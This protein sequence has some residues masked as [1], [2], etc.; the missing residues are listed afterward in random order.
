MRLS[1]G[2]LPT[3]ASTVALACLIAGPAT[4][5]ETDSSAAF[6]LEEIVVTAQKTVET[7]SKTPIALSVFSDEQ[8]KDSGVHN[9]D[10]L[11]SIAP[12]VQ[13]ANGGHGALITIRGVTTTDN[14]S[15]GEQAV[16][17]NIDGMAIGRPQI[18][19]LAFFDLE[20]VEVL[21]GP[22]GTLYGKSSTGGAINVITAKPKSDFDAAASVE[23]GNYNTRRAEGMVNVPVTDTFAIRLAANSNVRDGFLNP[24]LHYG[25]PQSVFT[26]PALN[27]EDNQSGRLSALWNFSDTGSLLLQGTAGHIGGTGNTSGR[28]LFYRYDQSGSAAREVYANPMASGV[29][30]KYYKYNAEL[31]MDVGAMRLTYVGGY[32][33]FKGNDNPTPSTGLPTGDNPT[34]SWSQYIADNT[35]DSHEVR[36]SNAQPQRL[37]YVL[38]ANYWKEV[39]DEVDM[40][41]QTYANISNTTVPGSNPPCTVPAPNTV[42]GCSAPSPNIV[43]VNQHKAQGYFGQLNFHATDALKLTAGLRY[44]SDSMFRNASIA[45]GP[46]PAAYWT[47]ANGQP[48]YPGV[49]C[50]P[51]VNGLTGPVKMND[52]G[53]QAADK[54]T[55]RIGADYQ[56]GDN[57]MIYGYVA[58]GYKAGSFNDICPTVSPP[59]PCSYG[60]EDMIAYEVGYKGR[61]RPNLEINSSVY[62]YDYS[63][64]Q[65]TQPTFL[66]PNLSGGAPTVII[67]TTLV[68][69][70][71]YGWEG[72]MHWNITGND[73]F[74]ISMT[75]ANG[76]YDDGPGHAEAGLGYLVRKDWSNK[77]LD[78]LPKWSSIVSYEHRW[79][80]SGGG[81][82]SARLSSKISDS[83]YQSELGGVY[84]GP[85]FG[86]PPGSPPPFNFT[87]FAV[88]PTQYEQASFT[89]TD[90]NLGYTSESGKYSVDAYVR[91]IEDKMQLQS[92]PQNVY[93]PGTGNPDQV[94]AAVNAPL[95]MGIRMSVKY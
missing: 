86:G 80:M 85:P 42:A 27:D 3:A 37:E 62:Y 4:G 16:S 25:R 33:S 39:T 36:I 68:P 79:D 2:L 28:A 17:F 43:G 8:L 35:Y 95:T 34:Y 32:L 23:F 13:I 56:I 61:V 31:N 84:N 69:M 47:A 64:F 90:F 38:G 59:G 1:T 93:A 71:L 51:L 20:R 74:D 5:A 7:A 54:T 46:P 89:R 9:V 14:T 83:Y 94:T 18:T 87:T 63:K 72:E 60:P 40:G 65:F 57:H 48:C 73:R 53:S 15:K 30:D 11:G 91:N 58:T 66:A 24:V 44:S 29:D 10:T 45:A 21:R 67:Y 19:Q 88:E 81:S 76:Y 22:Q 49:P 92:P 6:E 70:T 12:S 77:R 41:W 26:Q 78:N 82:I 75:L 50:Q 52:V 55:W